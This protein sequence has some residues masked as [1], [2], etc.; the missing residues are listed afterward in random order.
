V[1]GVMLKTGRE[2]SSKSLLSWQR[3]GNLKLFQAPLII[4]LKQGEL[5]L[6]YLVL[7]YVYVWQYTLCIMEWY[8]CC[9]CCTYDADVLC[10]L[11]ERV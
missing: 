4:F 8:L 6:A 5:I 7:S 10:Y 1:A 9:V 11:L 3:V 2:S